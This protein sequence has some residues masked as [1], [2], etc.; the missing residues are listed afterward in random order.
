MTRMSKTEGA[1]LISSSVCTDGPGSISSTKEK[2]TIT[3][4][5]KG[6][7]SIS[8]ENAFQNPLEGFLLCNTSSELY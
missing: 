8:Q 7:F 3:D 6:P 4:Q 2:E 5:Y 1:L